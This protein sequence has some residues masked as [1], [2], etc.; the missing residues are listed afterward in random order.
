MESIKSK[1]TKKMEVETVCTIQHLEIQ[2][3]SIVIE[4]LREMCITQICRYLLDQVF[5]RNEN[6]LLPQ[7]WMGKVIAPIKS[8]AGFDLDYKWQVPLAEYWIKKNLKK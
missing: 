4:T 1:E 5:R 3:L 8:E 7:K 6:G 2:K